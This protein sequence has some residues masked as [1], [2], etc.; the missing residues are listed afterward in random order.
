MY[1]PI[2]PLMLSPTILRITT[3][4]TAFGLVLRHHWYYRLAVEVF[5]C[6]AVRYMGGDD[7][8][9]RDGMGVRPFRYLFVEEGLEA[10]GY[11]F[12]RHCEDRLRLELC[13]S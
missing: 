10:E 4:P 13:A 3:P 12:G 7:E 11:F 6:G 1:R 5:V 9:R 8:I 2:L